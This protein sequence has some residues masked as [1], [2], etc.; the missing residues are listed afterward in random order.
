MTQRFD[1]KKAATKIYTRSIIGRMMKG[2]RLRKGLTCLTL[3]NTSYDL[4][5]YIIQNFNVKYMFCHEIDEETYVKSKKIADELPNVILSPTDVFNVKG[6]KFD[7]VWLDLCASFQCA[8]KVIEFIK[9]NDFKS[10]AIIAITFC[11]QRGTL[12]EELEKQYPDYKNSGF[13][14]HMLDVL[15]AGSTNVH[16]ADYMEKSSGSLMS[17]FIFKTPKNERHGSGKN[18]GT[19]GRRNKEAQLGTVDAGTTSS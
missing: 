19:E 6:G 4:E 8:D 16:H 18:S 13:I 5:R 10:G 12:S 2:L 11:K 14:F 17:F 7:L 15:P 3:P 9:N 1:A